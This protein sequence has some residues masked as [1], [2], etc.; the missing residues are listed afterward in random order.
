MSGIS[1][2]QQMKNGEKLRKARLWKIATFRSAI[3]AKILVFLIK[4]NRKT[5]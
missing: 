3:S 1:V 4:A 2:H 5:S